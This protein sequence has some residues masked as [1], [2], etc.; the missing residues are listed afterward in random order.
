[1]EVGNGGNVGFGRDG[2]VGRVGRGV[3]G[4][5]GS[6]AVG[7]DGIAGRGG[8]VALG[9]GGIVGNAGCAG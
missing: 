4:S 9:S 5:G 2:L 8:S 7:R 6:V 1:M 3:L